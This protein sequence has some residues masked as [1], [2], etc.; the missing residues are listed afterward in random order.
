M[1]LFALTWL[2]GLCVEILRPSW[3]DGLRMT[4]SCVGPG[5]AGFGGGGKG[6]GKNPTRKCGGWG[7]RPPEP[8]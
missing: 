1:G 4:A 8:G 6:K 7:T 5:A 2:L 3:L